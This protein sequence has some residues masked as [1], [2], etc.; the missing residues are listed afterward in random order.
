MLH[1]RS[2]FGVISKMKIPNHP[3]RRREECTSS[4]KTFHE[5]VDTQKC[6]NFVFSNLQTADGFMDGS[7]ESN[8]TPDE[9]RLLPPDSRHKIPL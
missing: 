5:N 7:I 6:S 3:F 1:S 2:E 9:E 8:Q 4:T